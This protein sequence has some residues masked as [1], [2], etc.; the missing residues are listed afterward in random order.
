M[1]ETEL[2]AGK[3]EASGSHLH[4]KESG[5]KSIHLK[6]SARKAFVG[7]VTI[8]QGRELNEY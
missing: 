6:E 8:F 7:N 5:W 1:G 3:E 2:T 4:S